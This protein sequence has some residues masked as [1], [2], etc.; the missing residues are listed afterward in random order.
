MRPD[1]SGSDCWVK[2]QN[3]FHSFLLFASRLD[4]VATEETPQVFFCCCEGNF[5]NQN[6]THLP[7]LSSPGESVYW[8]YRRYQDLNPSSLPGKTWGQIWV[9]SF[10][11]G[12]NRAGP[13][14]RTQL[15]VGPLKRR[16]VFQISEVWNRT[17]D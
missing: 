16:V 6:F 7:D 5:C 17:S 15:L 12:P 9:K 14:G 3:R 13:M 10:C 4:C 2:H 11:I 1:F 8:W